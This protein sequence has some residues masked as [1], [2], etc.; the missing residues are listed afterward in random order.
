MRIVNDGGRITADMP[1]NRAVPCPSRL[2]LPTLSHA[3]DHARTIRIATLSAYEQELESWVP[4]HPGCCRAWTLSVHGGPV[5]IH[6][7][8]AKGRWLLPGR[9]QRLSR[10]APPMAGRH[11]AFAS[12]ATARV[13]SGWPLRMVSALTRKTGRLLSQKARELWL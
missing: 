10:T 12:A 13:A 9:G 11:A 7:P 1:L 2:A 6:A 8:D 5:D 3:H 4:A